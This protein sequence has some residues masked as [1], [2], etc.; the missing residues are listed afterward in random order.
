M[1]CLFATEVEAAGMNRM[2]FLS[3]DIRKDDRALDAENLSK[4]IGKQTREMGRKFISGIRSIWKFIQRQLDE[5]AEMHNRLEQL[6]HQDSRYLLDLHPVTPLELGR[7]NLIKLKG[8][9]RE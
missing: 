4:S 3:D 2:T 8:T 9:K 6:R 5:G 7:S 1:N